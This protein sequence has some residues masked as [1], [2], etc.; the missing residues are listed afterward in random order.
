M[1]GCT[2]GG[3]PRVH[4]VERED[5]IDGLSRQLRNDRARTC[6]LA[7]QNLRGNMKIL[8]QKI[9]PF[10]NPLIVRKKCRV[11]IEAELLQALRRRCMNDRIAEGIET[12]EINPAT[13]GEELLV[14]RRGIGFRS[15][16]IKR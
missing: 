8:S 5:N 16:K 2:A 7:T 10:K 3:E 15:N 11:A 9:E 13:M 14:E 6:Q 12:P 4:F 1:D